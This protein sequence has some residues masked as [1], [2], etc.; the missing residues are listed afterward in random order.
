MIEIPPLPATAKEPA[1]LVGFDLPANV[2]D[3]RNVSLE[4]LKALADTADIEPAGM[5]VCKR[6]GADPATFIGS[7]KVAE[8]TAFCHAREIHL[9]LFDHD[10]SPVQCRN[11]EEAFQGKV[12]DRTALILEIFARRARTREGQLQVE[13]AQ[14]EYLLPRLT[15]LWSHLSRQY[16]GAGTRGPGEK[17]LEVD[18]RRVQSRLRH[19]HDLLEEI[20]CQRATQRKRRQRSDIPVVAIVGYTNSGKSTLMHTLT[21][22]DVL[23]ENKLFATLDPT[24]RTHHLPSGECYLFSDTVG[25]IR[26]LPHALVE[27]FKA[28][29]EEVHQADVLLHIADASAAD[30]DSQLAAVHAVLGELDAAQKPQVLALNKVD[31]LSHQAKKAIQERFPDAALISAQYKYGFADLFA[32][33][34]AATPLKRLRTRLRL[35][36]HKS[37][38]LSQLYAQ[39]KVLS[40][41]YQQ[42]VIVVDAFVPEALQQE[43]RRYRSP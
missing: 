35:P 15:N 27:A 9:V 10:L 42:E 39:G 30:V 11:L 1:C 21:K 20:R 17:Q 40:V 7:G 41:D 4:E 38:L 34:R 18:R 28:T 13:C 2:V 12:I 23:V 36:P 16:G 37:Y 6:F 24:T 26:N 14:L 3:G 33:L 29:L 25:F 32:R 43:T 19:L 22:A 5:F 31:L 8:I